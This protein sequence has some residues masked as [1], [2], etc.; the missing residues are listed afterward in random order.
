MLWFKKKQNELP[1]Y[2]KINTWLG[3]NG[4]NS[5]SNLF[6][7]DIVGNVS[8]L[9]WVSGPDGELSWGVKRNTGEWVYLFTLYHNYV[10][11]E[12][13]AV[14]S[15]RF[16]SVD[17][18]LNQLGNRAWFRCQHDSAKANSFIKF[19]E[20]Y[21]DV[22]IKEFFPLWNNGGKIKDIVRRYKNKEDF[23]GIAFCV[24]DDDDVLIEF[25]LYNCDGL[26]STKIAKNTISRFT[27]EQ[28]SEQYEQKQEQSTVNKTNHDKYI[29]NGKL[30]IDLTVPAFKRKDGKYCV[31]VDISKSFILEQAEAV[32]LDSLLMSMGV[33]NYEGFI[34]GVSEHYIHLLDKHNDVEYNIKVKSAYKV[35]IICEPKEVETPEYTMEEL[36]KKL[37]HDFKIKK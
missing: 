34:I 21:K 33:D 5:I 25:R 4:S 20:T 2:V 29:Y 15:I 22:D 12:D 27:F 1:D 17:E 24:R 28:L 11:Y 36:T 23:F 6:S 30:P 10:I 18:F 8:D 3:M 14:G 16:A 37:G 31:A 32:R 35:H 19:Q 7:V 13:F 26:L 9:R